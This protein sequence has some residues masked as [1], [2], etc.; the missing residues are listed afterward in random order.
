MEIK[1]VCHFCLANNVLFSGVTSPPLIE[2]PFSVK[3][4]KIHS[5]AM[6]VFCG[7]ESS[8]DPLK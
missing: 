8:V 3:D 2:N 4:V 7:K 6:V 1:M 5:A